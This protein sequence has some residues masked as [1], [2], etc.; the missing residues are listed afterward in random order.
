MI[1]YIL[2]D[3]DFDGTDAAH[4][5]YDRGLRRGIDLVCSRVSDM[6]GGGDSGG[7]MFGLAGLQEIREQ[8]RALLGER[9]TLHQQLQDKI[10]HTESLAFQLEATKA[11][12]DQLRAEKSPVRPSVT[13]EGS[14]TREMGQEGQRTKPD[15]KGERL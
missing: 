7:G 1:T 10:T 13:D 4:P 14:D 11:E 12:R 15:A 6:L 2:D 9:D 5:A 3:P 8:I